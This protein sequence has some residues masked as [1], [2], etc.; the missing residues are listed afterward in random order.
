[1]KALWNIVLWFSVIP[2]F[3]VS[4][5]AIEKRLV[6]INDIQRTYRIQIP[7]CYSP[8]KS[9]PLVFV[10]HGGGGSGENMPAFTGFGTLAETGGFI[11]V[12]PDGYQKYWN[13]GRDFSFSRMDDVK[14]LR[15]VFETV[16][17]E[18]NVDKTRVYAVGISNGAMMC[19]RLGIEMFD[20]FAAIAAV[21]GNLPMKLADGKPK[22]FV[23]VLIMNGTSDSLVPYDGGTIQVFGKNRGYVISTEMTVEF[24]VKANKCFEKLPE[25]N[26]DINKNDG[27]RIV[28]NTY[29]NHDN[30]TKVVLYK[31]IGGGH[32]WPGGIQYLAEKIVGKVNRDIKAEQVIW[33]FFSTCKKEQQ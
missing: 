13:D 26:V 10:L 24:W 33:E 5:Q 25:K 7:A 23:S 21:C 19:Y 30:G 20:V 22:N 2:C 8:D 4:N 1:M 11:A 14:F 32:T 15:T 18:F 31:I 17:K 3:A 12:Y 6:N 29:V 9:F 16:S 27:S 28:I